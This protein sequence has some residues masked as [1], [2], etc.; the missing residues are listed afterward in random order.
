VHVLVHLA[1][2]HVTDPEVA[3]RLRAA[4]ESAPDPTKAVLRVLDDGAELL[5]APTLLI[6]DGEPGVLSIGRRA[7]APGAGHRVLEEL[8]VE[9]A[10]DVEAGTLELHVKLDTAEAGDGVLVPLEED[11]EWRGAVSLASPPP[12]V[13]L[14]E[15]V[16]L[17]VT[18]ELA[19]DARLRRR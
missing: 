3:E 14:G 2:I 6:R 16:L 7:P 4:A 9:A 10:P 11:L 5:A 19:D 12:A 15:D 17:V 8:V 18:A 13:S 1:L